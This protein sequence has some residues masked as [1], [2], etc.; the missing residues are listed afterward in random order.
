EAPISSAPSEQALTTA[1]IGVPKVVLALWD[2]GQQV[3]PFAA[4]LQR[5]FVRLPREV[6]DSVPCSP[7]RLER[8]E[9]AELLARRMCWRGKLEW[10]TVSAADQEH[11]LAD[12]RNSVVGRVE[13]LPG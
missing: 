7:I 2:R 12:L 9:T 6:A 8:V 1:A 3:S 11:S 4:D 13:H 5:G 10:A